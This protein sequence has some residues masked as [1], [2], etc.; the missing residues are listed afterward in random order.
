MLLILSN[1]SI[2]HCSWGKDYNFIEIGV[3]EESFLSGINF[4]VQKRSYSSIELKKYGL[5]LK[6]IS[7]SSNLE[8][9][10]PRA[11]I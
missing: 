3:D 2:S 7:Q 5:F 4:L 6:T 9:K 1:N 10:I 8:K 11:K